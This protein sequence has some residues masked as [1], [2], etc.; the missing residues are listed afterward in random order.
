MT[1]L[2]S[3]ILLLSHNLMTSSNLAITRCGATSTAELVHTQTPFIGV[4]LPNSVDNHQY[5]NAKYYEKQDCCWILEQSSFN[6][7]NLYNLIVETIKNKN[8]LEIIRENMKK[9]YNNNVFS[10][11]EDKIREII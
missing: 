4:P 8:K 10:K 5:L 9:N 1:Y 3:I 7:E 2:H 6:E 11:I